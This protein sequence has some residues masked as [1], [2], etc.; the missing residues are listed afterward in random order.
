M[1]TEWSSGR[2]DGQRREGAIRPGDAPATFP[3]APVAGV[4]PTVRTI[5]SLDAEAAAEPVEPQD[6]TDGTSDEEVDAHRA[7]VDA[8]DGLLDQVERALARLDD[9]TYG[10]CES[11]G[12]AI[13]DGDLAEDPLVL[14][15]RACGPADLRSGVV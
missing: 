7:A 12:A 6:V 14:V 15:C 9:G 11:C 8:V 1:Q 3:V 5:G 2:D 10:R 13:A 4:E